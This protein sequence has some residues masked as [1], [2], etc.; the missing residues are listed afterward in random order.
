MRS[1]KYQI[2]KKKLK[3]ETSTYYCSKMIYLLCTLSFLYQLPKRVIKQI[4]AA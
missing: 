2:S 4:Y 1:Y 3:H